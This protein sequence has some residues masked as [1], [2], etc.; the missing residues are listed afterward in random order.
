MSTKSTIW[1]GT[2]QSGRDCHLYWE[3]AE[4]IPSKAA[5]IF[6]SIE[7]RG[8]KTAYSGRSRSAF[9]GDVDHDS[10]LKPISVPG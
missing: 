3:L 5:P 4:R 6:M 7:A 8:K 10:G 1:L 9:R 2:D